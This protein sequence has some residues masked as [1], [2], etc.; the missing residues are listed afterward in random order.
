MKL[1]DRKI[2]VIGLGYVGLPLAAL[3][4]KKGYEV[5]G[6]DL[7]ER[8]VAMLNQGKCH[9]RDEAVEQLLAAAIASGK[10]SATSD[11][12]NVAD[13]DVYLICVPT[14]VDVNNEPDLEPLEGACR[15]VAPHLSS[16][17]LVVVE[18]TVFPGTCEQVV[19]PLLEKLSELDSGKDFHLAHCPERFALRIS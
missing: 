3:C 12:A 1:L 2:A 7:S 18:S 16:E 4:A 5:I 19:A 14:P 6:L 13:C 17:D 9:I 15:V 8:I 11:A 10:F